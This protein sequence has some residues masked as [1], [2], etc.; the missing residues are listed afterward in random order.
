[1]DSS[2]AASQPSSPAFAPT[3]Q[4][5]SDDYFDINKFD[6]LLKRLQ[7]SKARTQESAE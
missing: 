3:G 6:Q 2:L 5:S 4:P 7:A 1:M